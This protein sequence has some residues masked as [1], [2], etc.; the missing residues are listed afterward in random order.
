MPAARLSP[1]PVVSIAQV[2]LTDPRGKVSSYADIANRDG[3]VIGLDQAAEELPI[4]DQRPA[5]GMTIIDPLRLR[6]STFRER[7]T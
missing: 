5:G 2:R 1:A 6:A 4:L 7:Q 3:R